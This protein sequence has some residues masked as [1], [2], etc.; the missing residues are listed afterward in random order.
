MTAQYVGPVRLVVLDIGGCVV[1]GPQDLSGR[2]AN[3]D[4]IGVKAPVIS[5]DETLQNWGIDLSWEQIREPMGLYKKDHLRELLTTEE[6]S[7]QF[8]EQHGREWTED[9]LEEMFAS[10]SDVQAEVIVRDELARPVEG[11]ADTIDTLRGYGKSVSTATG[12]TA[13]AAN[14]LYEKLAKDHGITFDFETHSDAVSAG[15]PAPWMIQQGMRE[16]GVEATRAVIKVGDTTKD[17]EAGHN[18]GVWTVGVYTTGNDG[19][20]ELRDAGA[21]YLIPSIRELPEIVWTVENRLA[22][23]ERR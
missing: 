21:D 8:K 16:S 1:D 13:N 19:F 22:R 5:F 4:G 7:R 20:D 23:G 17:I 15:R 10:F 3:D 6:A 14:A 12:Y 18:A 2:Y 11:A 9:D